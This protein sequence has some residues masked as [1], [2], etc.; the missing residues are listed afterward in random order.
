MAMATYVGQNHG[1]HRTDRIRQGIKDGC[2]V[3]L[4]YCAVAWG[5]IVSS[6]LTLWSWCWAMPTPPSQRVPSST[7][8]S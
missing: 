4:L 1:A 7:S 6:S 8:A 2:M 3:Q 5:V